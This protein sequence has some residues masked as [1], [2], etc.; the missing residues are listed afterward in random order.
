MKPKIA[1]PFLLMSLVFLSAFYRKEDLPASIK[2]GELVYK[3]NCMSCHMANGQG[4]E[5]SFPPLAKT[6]RLSSKSRLVKI[7]RN[8]MT[9]EIVVNGNRYTGQG[10]AEGGDF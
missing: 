4:L 1:V 10:I 3:A 7:V 6:G 9:E 2:R 8:G 5:G